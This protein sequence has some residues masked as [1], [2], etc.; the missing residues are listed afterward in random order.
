MKKEAMN[1]KESKERC[2]GEELEGRNGKGK[3]M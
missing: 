1:S 3:M 2:M